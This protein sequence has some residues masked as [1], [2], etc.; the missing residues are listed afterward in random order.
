MWVVVVAAVEPRDD[1]GGDSSAVVGEVGEVG[2]DENVDSAADEVEE[3]VEEDAECIEDL[4]SPLVLML[5]GCG[6]N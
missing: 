1:A 4:A 3:E 5:S 2:S 6:W